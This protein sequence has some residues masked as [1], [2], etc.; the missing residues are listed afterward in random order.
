MNA[1]AHQTTSAADAGLTKFDP[2]TLKNI[3]STAMVSSNGSA[4]MPSTMAE[5]MELGKMM[6]L[7]NFV[8]P[9]LRQKPGDCLAVVMQSMRWGMDPFAVANKTYFVNDRMAYE[10]QLVN[11]VLNARA[12][13]SGRL[14]VSWDGEG[15]T[16]T[17]RVVG[18]IKGDPEPHTVWQE[19]ATITTRNSPLWKQSP[20]QQLAYYTTRMWAR[21][22]CPEVLLGVYTDD[23]VRDMG[24][25]EPQGDGSYAPAAE[26][27]APP[28]P[29]R[30][31]VRREAE[32]ARQD[33]YERNRQYRE[34]MRA[35]PAEK[36][37][38]HDP[39]TGEIK[40]ESTV[41]TMTLPVALKTILQRMTKA[42]TLAIVEATVSDFS[43]ELDLMRMDAPDLYAQ[44]MEAIAGK[45][46]AFRK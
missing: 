23:E 6:C 17:C 33:D 37:I 43:V 22:Y 5:A 12:P 13:L 3:G 15:A 46:A 31:T 29:T 32:D 2:E 20:R 14:Q 11:A 21:L 27:Q 36:V 9:H 25:L 8:P 34:T 7:S 41:V 38:D 39:Q 42:G 45:R 30:E 24:K 1:N 4:F 35:T 26:I 40:A 18:H 16:L 19:L 28:R 10:A 44:A